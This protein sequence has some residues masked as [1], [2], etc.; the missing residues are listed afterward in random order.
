[1]T[2]AMRALDDDEK[3]FVARQMAVQAYEAL[4]ALPKVF[5]KEFRDGL[6]RLQIPAALCDQLNAET[7]TLAALRVKHSSQLQRIRNFCGA[8]RD[9][10]GRRQLEEIASI[11]PLRIADLLA[12]IAQPVK[13]LA[14]FATELTLQC[15]Q[16]EVMLR[17][18]VD[19]RRG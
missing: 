5:N 14:A 17:D 3:R 10:D 12:D 13:G 6:Q 1:M 15:T 11:E 2:Q 19:S 8:H 9:L 16:L 7:K 18:H 4:E